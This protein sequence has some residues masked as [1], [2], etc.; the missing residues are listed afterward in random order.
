MVKALKKNLRIKRINDQII[1][2]LQ[3]NPQADL[4]DYLAETDINL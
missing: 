4:A 3:P 1:I 2:R